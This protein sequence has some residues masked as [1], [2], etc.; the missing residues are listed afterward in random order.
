MP[1]PKSRKTVQSVLHLSAEQREALKSIV[2]LNLTTVSEY[3]F[4]VTDVA[5]K[6]QADICPLVNQSNGL[7]GINEPD[8]RIGKPCAGWPCIKC[9]HEHSCK[10]GD[11]TGLFEM[12]AENQAFLVARGYKAVT[13]YETVTMTVPITKVEPL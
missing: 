13:T 5:M 9:A 4:A 12:D 8:H 7:H 1:R 10:N 3:L 11:Y 6:Q 2:S